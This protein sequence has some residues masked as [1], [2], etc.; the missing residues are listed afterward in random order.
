M[1]GT[2]YKIVIEVVDTN[3][4]A[5][6]VSVEVDYFT[7]ETGTPG[8]I[9]VKRIGLTESTAIPPVVLPGDR[10]EVIQAFANTPV[11]TDTLQA[12]ADA[13]AV[14]VL[15]AGCYWAWYD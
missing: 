11:F 1:I 7:V 14:A 3:T 8:N 12:K 2:T 10:W 15:A 13:A 6:P 5:V 9:S 4:R